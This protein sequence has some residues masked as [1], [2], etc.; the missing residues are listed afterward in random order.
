[1][2]SLSK[3]SA[4]DY[5]AWAKQAV[6]GGEVDSSAGYPDQY[7]SHSDDKERARSLINEV[8]GVAAQIRQAEE[9]QHRLKFHPSNPALSAK[10][11]ARERRRR[12]E[13][14][15]WVDRFIDWTGFRP[16]L[17][18]RARDDGVHQPRVTWEEDEDH[19]DRFDY[20]REEASRPK[21][22]VR[23]EDLDR[24][25]TAHISAVKAELQQLRDRFSNYTHSIR[26]AIQHR[27]TSHPKRT[28]TAPQETQPQAGSTEE[29]TPTTTTST[30]AGD[31]G[32]TEGG[33]TA[34]V[35]DNDTSS[36]L[37]SSPSS[38]P[39]HPLLDPLHAILTDVESM[40]ER[41]LLPAPPQPEGVWQRLMSTLFP[42]HLEQ[43]ASAVW[44][45]AT[46]EAREEAVKLREAM[47]A[48][49][50][51]LTRQLLELKDD[52]VQG[53]GEPLELFEQYSPE[54]VLISEQ[55]R[56]R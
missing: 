6:F 45:A 3:A 26:A 43:R 33:A 19:I 14:L 1:M 22:V 37:P 11:L 31:L 12:G 42:S 8:H 56:S 38:A 48:E 50:A 46:E 4:G 7:A 54:P 49:C 18:Q 39:S 9:E 36:S 24:S 17:E 27:L 10:D 35:G 25:Q 32:G 34:R 5:L 23:E 53:K 28:A 2:W 29:Q 47:R 16:Y 41:P 40:T 13:E 52:V 51:E 55:Q 21:P 44:R 30:P 20:L 15:G